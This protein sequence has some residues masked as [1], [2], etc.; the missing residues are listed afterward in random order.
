MIM[1]PD[2]ADV[3]G[4][5]KNTLI[6]DNAAVDELLRPRI[7]GLGRHFGMRVLTYLMAI[8]FNEFAAIMLHFSGLNQSAFELSTSDDGGLFRRTGSSLLSCHDRGGRVCPEETQHFPAGVR[9][10]RVRV[11]SARAAA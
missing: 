4:I 8:A 9:T 6:G 3:P 7:G 1:T 5:L 10:A 11:R 2:K